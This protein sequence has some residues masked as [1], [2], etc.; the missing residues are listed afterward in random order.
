[1]KTLK[2]IDCGT[3]CLCGYTKR[4]QEDNLRQEAIKWIKDL[5]K[6]H[7]EDGSC[8]HDNDDHYYFGK[9][10]NGDALSQ[11]ECVAVKDFI[12]HFFNISDEEVRSTK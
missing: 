2:D 1:M 3:C 8:N 10:E 7:R 12:K 9:R 6:C 4:I 11:Q 5:E